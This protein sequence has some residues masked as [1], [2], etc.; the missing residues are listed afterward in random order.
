MVSTIT[1][2]HDGK[3]DGVFLSIGAANPQVLK[4]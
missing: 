3:Y 1:Y 2:K 4:W